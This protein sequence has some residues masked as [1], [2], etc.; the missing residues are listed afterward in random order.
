MPKITFNNQN[1]VF[2]NSINARVEQYFK[3]RNLKKTGDK[4]LYFK[5]SILIAA[6]VATYFVLLTIHM[7]PFIA[8]VLCCMF[9]FIQATIG[10]NVMHD[11]NHGSFSEKKWINNL[12]GLSANLMGVNAWLWKQK[13]NIIHHTYTNIDG[14]DDDIGKSPFLRMCPSQKQLKLHRY[15]YIYCI[16]LYGVMSFWMF[17][18]DFSKYFGKRIQTTPIHNMEF[19]EHLIF[20][21]TKVLYIFFY[22]VLPIW[23]VG[24]LPALIGF[25]LMH[26]ILGVT[27]ALVFQLAH[28]VEATHFV[29]A[30]H[31]SLHI[32]DEWAVHQVQTTADFATNNKIISWFTGG[33]NY[34][35]EHHL[36]PKISHVHYPVIHK[37]VKDVCL[38]FSIRFNNYPSM[39][40]ALRSH[41]RFMK[42]LG[43]Q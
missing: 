21:V 42:Q 9:G 4:T 15:Q 10:F 3:D 33:L 8:A 39:A 11:A 22:I 26:A 1:K 19:K 29:D 30:N 27:L 7:N 17:V 13:H 43:M 32:E 12:M 25:A 35:V 24:F 6:G 41:L 5:S 38:K 18:T 40:S 14:V 20:W 36:F 31:A 28:V 16:P 23:V 34:Q 37:I 2:F